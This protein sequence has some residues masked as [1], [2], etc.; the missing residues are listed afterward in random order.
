MAFAPIPARAVRRATA[1]AL[2]PVSR[3]RWQ[4]RRG[5]LDALTGQP[6]TLVR[7]STATAVDLTGATYT[8]GYGMPRWEHRAWSG[9]SRYE[10]GLR[11]TTDDVTWPASWAPETATL[12]VECAE[13]GTRT[14]SGAGLVSVANAAVTG[15]RLVLDSDGTDYRATIHTGSTSASVS[16]ATAT[17][18]TGQMAQLALQL[19]DDGTDQRVR[20]LLSVGGGAVTT[21]AWSS[22]VTRAAAWGTGATLRVNRVGSAGTPGDTWLRQIAWCPGLL[23]LDEMA[24]RL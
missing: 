1:P 3:F 12:Y 20:L 7:A 15:A 24:A 8:A 21:T 5:T 10:L 22:T 19:E 13:A 4:A 16:L 6:G 14:T 9:S 2:I 17:P 11:L 18:T 23:T